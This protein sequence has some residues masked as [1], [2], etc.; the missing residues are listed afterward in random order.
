MDVSERGGPGLQVLEIGRRRANRPVLSAEERARTDSWPF[1]YG[2][3]DDWLW[4]SDQIVI[5]ENPDHEGWYLVHNPR[6]STHVDVNYL[7][8]Q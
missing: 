3:V 1:E 8:P 2:Y 5:D 4:D 6:L 7:G